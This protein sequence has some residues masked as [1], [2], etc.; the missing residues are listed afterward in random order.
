MKKRAK[1]NDQVDYRDII[2]E[3]EPVADIKVRLAIVLYGK[4][5]T[6]KTTLSATFPKPML[7]VDVGE[8]G[9]ESIS[10]VKGVDVLPVTEWDQLDK[11]FW[12]L[13]KEGHKKYKTFSIDTVGG[14]QDMAIKKVLED[15][16]Q[17][18]EQG[19]LGGWG[20]MTKRN[21]GSVS[22]DLKSFVHNF[23]EL[24]MNKI[25][26]A[27][28]RVSK[29]DE[30]EDDTTAGIAPSVGPRLMPSA[31][32]VLN[33]SVGVIGNTFI[34]EREKIIK[35]GKK[36]KTKRTIEYGLRVGPHPYYTTKV[37]KPRNII[38]PAVLRDPTYDK[39]MALVQGGDDD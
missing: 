4:S 38:V 5:G 33:A 39:I 18:I 11:I 10:E 28:N 14:V 17:S 34:Y 26:I 9:T 19:K 7:V 20:T 32:E 27:H 15:Q 24:P 36:E 8:R 21:W 29:E 37:R 6:G 1:S 25:F 2:D 30:N 16:G 12:Y 3:I 23:N 13:R 35:I 22:S 31:A